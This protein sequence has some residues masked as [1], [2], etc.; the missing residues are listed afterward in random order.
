MEDAILSPAELQALS[1]YKLAGKICAWLDANQIRYICNARGW[2]LVS[3]AVMLLALG[4]QHLPLAEPVQLRSIN[5]D[6]LAS[7]TGR[8]GGHG[9]AKDAGS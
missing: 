3:R 2:P 4:E 6:R 7:L 1:G 5:L 9:A 8:K